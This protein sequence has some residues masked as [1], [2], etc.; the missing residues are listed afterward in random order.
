MHSPFPGMD[1]YL[2]GYLWADVHHRLATKIS[3][4]LASQIQPNYVAR[5]EISVIEDETFESEIGVMYPDIEIIRTH[6]EPVGAGIVLEPVAT[7]APLTISVPQVKLV[8]VE[9]RD[10]AKNRLVTSI[11]ILS[12]VNKRAP[13]LAKY[14][15]KR[16]RLKQAEVHLLELDLLRRGTR[17]W[18]SSR[19]PKTDYIIALTRATAYMMEMWP[20]S[21]KDN[22][23]ILPVP[24]RY[25]DKDALLDL[26]RALIEVYDEAYYH[27][28]IDYQAKPPP[29][30]ITEADMAWIRTL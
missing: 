6:P 15:A 23:P 3:Q 26:G 17:V 13:N 21:L 10:T 30:T 25:P 24:L 22:L 29:P 1:P 11:E 19:I 2:E 4:L 28:S 7:I 18:Q 9:I 20:L 8:T 14:R 12:P 5:L 27:L 16:D